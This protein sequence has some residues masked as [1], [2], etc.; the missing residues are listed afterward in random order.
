MNY[1]K[2]FEETK[3][4][5]VTI[6]NRFFMAP[7]FPFGLAYGD[8]KTTNEYAEYYVE[9]A[10]GGTGLIITGLCKADNTAEVMKPVFECVK[11]PMVFLQSTADMVNRVHYHGSKIFLQISAGWGRALWPQFADDLVTPDADT[12]NRHEP[13]VLCRQITTEEVERIVKNFAFTAYV[14]KLAG[15]DGVEVHALHEGYLLDQFGMEIFNH[16]TDKYGGSIENR[17]RFALEIL[18]SI[19]HACGK[20]FPVSIRY[21]PKHFM[22]GIDQGGLAGEDFEEKGRDMEEGIQVAKLLESSGYDALNVD[23]GCY[24]SHYWNHPTVFSEDALYVPFAEEIKKAVNIPVLCA[25]RLD[26]AK[27]ANK[28]VEEDKIDMVGL[29][30][31]LLADPY[32][33]NKL[34]R[35]KEEE[36]CPCINCNIGCGSNVLK[37][38]HLG[39]T[40]NPQC[41]YEFMKPV[42]PLIGKPKKV[43]IIGAGPGGM[44]AACVA[45]ERG[46][47]VTIIERSNKVGGNLHAAA[48]ADFKYRDEMLAD[49]FKVRLDATDAELLLNTEATKDLVLSYKPDVII[50][51]TGAN[52]IV[53]NIEGQGKTSFVGAVDVLQ[54][55]ATIGENV[56]VLGGGQVG[57]ETAVMLAQQGK[58]VTIV[59][60]TNKLL[61]GP[62]KPAPQV[63][64]HANELFRV[65]NVNVMTST[66]LT[67]ITEKGAIVENN[68]GKVELAADTII[69]SVGFKSD[70]T[71]YDE[72][73]NAGVITYNIGD[74]QRVS[75][76]L[77][78][79]HSAFE[80]SNSL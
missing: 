19:K 78:A 17:Y 15:F 14:A 73:K 43:V 59:E 6:K 9:R 60:M 53:P 46:H 76:I 3:I 1:S 38:G 56:I 10:K 75:H 7:M 41:C 18:D 29:G 66:K 74:S 12:P 5:N 67:E 36:I 52:P 50:N 13:D 8:G 34:Q 62:N 72:L 55:K 77:N 31:A 58:K 51:A 39:C 23:V 37:V 63:E 11:D 48:G 65:H 40:V 25:G 57:V 47:N 68:D 35:G 69:Y 30:R 54:N 20:D 45:S 32:Y 79:V 16:R 27:L 21:S 70:A 24:D 22:R 4:G 42:K 64:M 33:V 61:G 71:L 80:I 26:I 44:E 2:L 49:Y 28:A